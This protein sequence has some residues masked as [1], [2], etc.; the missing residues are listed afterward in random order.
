MQRDRISL[1]PMSG[2]SLLRQVAYQSVSLILTG[3]PTTATESPKP[4][5]KIYVIVTVRTSSKNERKR[6]VGKM[7]ILQ[8]F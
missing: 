1:L 7:Q 2:E 4:R 5:P 3:K 8:Q 6:G